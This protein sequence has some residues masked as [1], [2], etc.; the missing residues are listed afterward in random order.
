MAMT[1]KSAAQK[2]S[3]HYDK[4]SDVLYAYID[5]PRPAICDEEADNIFIRRD[6]CTD[7]IVGFTIVGYKNFLNSYCDIVVPKK[8]PNDEIWLRNHSVIAT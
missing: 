7:E 8:V 6:P 3:F 2:V 1:E 4:K 5:K